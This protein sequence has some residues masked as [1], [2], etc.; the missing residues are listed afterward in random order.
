MTDI[1]A[2]TPVGWIFY[3]GKCAVRKQSQL[4]AWLPL[5]VLPIA[6]LPLRDLLPNWIFMWL[7]VTALFLGCKWLTWRRAQIRN[8]PANITHWF[9]YLFGWPGMDA[10]SFLTGATDQKPKFAEWLLAVGRFLAGIAIVWLAAKTTITKYPVLGAWI[11]M[12]GL[13]LILH[14]GLFHLLALGWQSTGLL[15]ANLVFTALPFIYGWTALK[16]VKP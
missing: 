10:N 12:F 2:R 3:D 16:G 13:V 7:F 5:L 4:L 8:R 1:K 15:I 9:G 14:F 6:T 11:G